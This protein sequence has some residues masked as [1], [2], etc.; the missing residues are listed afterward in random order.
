[1][2]STTSQMARLYLCFRWISLCAPVCV[3]LLS[4]I[5]L[6]FVFDITSD[7]IIMTS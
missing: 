3:I 6:L 1:M 5:A 4:F 7:E 2:D